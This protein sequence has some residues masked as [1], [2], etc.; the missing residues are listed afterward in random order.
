M[1]ET[2]AMLNFVV[3]SAASKAIGA[4]ETAF[5]KEAKFPAHRRSE[6][7]SQCNKAES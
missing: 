6:I 3:F 1:P 2:P 7:V 4:R 5:A